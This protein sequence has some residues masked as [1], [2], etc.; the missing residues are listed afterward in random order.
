M[1]F[2]HKLAQRLARLKADARTVVSATALVAGAVI[3][4]ERLANPSGPGSTV[5]QLVVFPK[6]VTLQQDQLQDFMAVGFTPA[7]DTAQISVTWSVTGGTLVDT[8]S[9]GGRHYA[10][11]NGTACG[12]FKVAGTS[13]PGQKS[14]T[15]NV[16][17]TCAQPAVASVVVSPASATVPVGQTLQLTGTPEDANGNPLSGRTISWSSGSSAVAAVNGNGLVTG[18]AAGAATITATSESKSGTAAITVT[19]VPVASV[20]VSP[21]TVSLQ[22]GQTQQLTATPKDAGGNSLSGRVVTWASGS[23]AVATV[24]GSG[25]VSGVAAGSATITATSESKS[26]TAAITVTS[27][28]VASV[29]VS[30]ATVS[31]QPGQTQ[32]LTATPNDAS[33]NALSGRMVTWASGNTAVATVSGSGLVS[34]VAA[35]STTITATSEGKSGGAS[36]TVTPVGAAVTLVGAGDIAECG[37]ATD[38][39]TAALLG[40]IGGTVFTAGDNAYPDGYY[41]DYANCW[42]PSWGRYQAVVH[43]AAGNHEYHDSITSGAADYYRYFFRE[44]GTVVGDSGRYY[45]SYDLGAWHVVVLNT[46]IDMSAGSSQEQWLRADLAAS[47]KQCTLAYMHYARFSSGSVHG[48]YSEVQPLWQALYDYGAEIAIAG[49]DH[50]YERFAP[51][52]PDGHLDTVRGIRA[53]VVGTGGG[54]LYSFGTP[55]PNSQVR[56]SSTWG[57]LKLT[58]AD[59]SYSWEFVPITGQTFTDSGS[60]T[61]H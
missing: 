38:D 20:T 39:S 37:D 43:P 15:G 21:A 45:Y 44:H 26:G 29:T 53:F 11:Y 4:C 2:L 19:S 34:G 47:T 13:H 18:V 61:C 46:F 31:L 54:G 8:S 49:H 56:N 5:S 32:Q 1:T 58:L 40:R 9:Q 35:G 12:S 24:S 30:P 52:T 55:L 36:V 42:A 23:T 27:V 60:G 3:A 57:V 25:L 14:D 16:T 10:H 41:Q 28:P 22:P 51:Q 7:G 33:G 48:S 6:V 59:G 17:V 50:E